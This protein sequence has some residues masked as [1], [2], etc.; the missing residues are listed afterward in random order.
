[1]MRQIIPAAAAAVAAA[2]SRM[3]STT[4]RRRRFRQRRFPTI[5]LWS[6]DRRL[7]GG[8]RGFGAADSA[9]TNTSKRRT[10]LNARSPRLDDGV[11]DS[12]LGSGGEVENWDE[13][14]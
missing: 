6:R 1:M 12:E 14:W 2:E 8:I 4:R 9:P 3:R 10:L 11:G 5:L 13:A 7:C